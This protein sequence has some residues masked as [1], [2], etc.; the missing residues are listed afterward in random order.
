MCLG[1]VVSALSSLLVEAGD[2]H[3]VAAPTAGASALQLTK[4]IDPQSIQALYTGAGQLAPPPPPEKTTWPPKQT[5]EQPAPPPPQTTAPYV[6]AFFDA[7]QTHTFVNP[8]DIKPTLAKGN[9]T[10]ESTLYAFNIKSS[11]QAKFKNLKNNVQL[12]FNA[13]APITSSDELTWLFLWFF[14]VRVNF[15][16]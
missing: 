7:K 11:D 10:L 12:G 6:Y 15:F 2:V 3:G 13:S 14:M 8:L 4:R 5:P 9:Y 16:L 1:S